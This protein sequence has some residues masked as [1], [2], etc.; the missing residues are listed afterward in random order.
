M[1]V[2]LSIAPWHLLI[3]ST[4]IRHTGRPQRDAYFATLAEPGV[5]R[6][7]DQGGGARGGVPPTVTFL[8]LRAASSSTKQARGAGGADGASEG[9]LWAQLSALAADR[10]WPAA[11]P[12]DG[13][14]SAAKAAAQKERAAATA[15]LARLIKPEVASTA[16]YTCVRCRYVQLF[17]SRAAA[18]FAALLAGAQA[19]ARRGRSR[20]IR[21]VVSKRVIRPQV[22]Q[23]ACQ[24]A[25]IDHDCF[26]DALLPRNGRTWYCRRQ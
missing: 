4:I 15:A 12:A 9:S 17:V 21:Y 20:S 22:V 1:L 13:G 25:E 5:G 18:A 7:D 2:A 19:A 24:L 8:W 23:A 14:A 26:G 3:E 6:E 16:V 10:G 11:T